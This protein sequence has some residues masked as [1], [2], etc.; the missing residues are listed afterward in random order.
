MTGAASS[1]PVT[2]STR[3]PSVGRRS[4]LEAAT[5]C[6][7]QSIDECALFDEAPA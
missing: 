1:G 6:A 2:S 5:G 3:R 7:C 4:M